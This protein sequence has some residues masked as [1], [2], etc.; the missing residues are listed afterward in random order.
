MAL[1]SQSIFRV[2]GSDLA[3]PGWV[4]LYGCAMSLLLASAVRMLFPPFSESLHGAGAPAFWLKR[5]GGPEGVSTGLVRV[6]Q[7]VVA[8]LAGL[9]VVTW[10]PDYPAVLKPRIGATLLVFVL[11]FAYRSWKR[12]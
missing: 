11:V 10:M 3:A 1:L 2:V 12:G 4:L 7:A 9:I 8:I 6:L 5:A